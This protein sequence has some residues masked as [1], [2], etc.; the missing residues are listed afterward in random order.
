[1][2]SDRDPSVFNLPDG[3]PGASSFLE[4]ATRVITPIADIVVTNV[5][6][7][8][9]AANSIRISLS[10]TNNDAGVNIR[11]GDATV[12]ATKGQ[13]VGPGSSFKTGVVAAVYAISEGANVTVSLTEETQ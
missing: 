2:L 11:I 13:R 10:G 12:T 9:R 5:A 3:V 8:L 4:S 7:L 6:T 1:M